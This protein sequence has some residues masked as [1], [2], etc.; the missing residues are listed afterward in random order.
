M[1]SLPADVLVHIAASFLTDAEACRFSQSDLQLQS[2]LRTRYVLKEP[3][4][5]AKWKEIVLPVSASSSAASA[6]ASSAFSSS[7]S[8]TAL[9]AVGVTAPWQRAFGRPRLLS[10]TTDE[11]FALT[12]L[13]VVAPSATEMHMYTPDEYTPTVLIHEWRL[14]AR[15][16][17]LTCSSSD[18]YNVEPKPVLSTFHLPDML[19]RLDLDEMVGR[20]L[21]NEQLHSEGKLTKFPATLT[22][23]RLPPWS[24]QEIDGRFFTLPP[25]LL[26][27]HNYRWAASHPPLPS[28]L[29]T[30]FALSWDAS[31][32]GCAIEFP[33]SLTSLTYDQVD[34]PKCASAPSLAGCPLLTE[35]DLDGCFE[36]PLSSFDL[37]P[38]LTRLSGIL[39]SQ[40]DGDWMPPDG[41]LVLH[42]WRDLSRASSVPPSVMRWPPQLREL[43]LPIFSDGADFSTMKLPE[44]LRVI[45]LRD[46]PGLESA[47][48]PSSLREMTCAIHPFVPLQWNGG[49]AVLRLRLSRFDRAVVDWHPPSSLTEL[50]MPDTW[51]QP[52]AQLHLPPRL[53]KL[54]F[55]SAFDQP[56]QADMKWPD[57]LETLTFGRGFNRSLAQWTPP[58]NL[59]LLRLIC[60]HYRL[61]S[62]TTSNLRVPR[63]LRRLRLES[64]HLPLL[65]FSSEEWPSLESLELHH[66]PTDWSNTQLPP[67]LRE[68]R[69]D[70]FSPES[71]ESF[72]IRFQAPAHL[73][74]VVV[75]PSKADYRHY[76]AP[77]LDGPTLRRIRDRLPPTCAFLQVA[78]TS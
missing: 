49:L 6:A 56:I 24:Q 15:L 21:I 47:Q 39:A 2:A 33:A 32:D 18:I 59:T 61:V 51:N 71:V 53:R 1:N 73:Q 76:G 22:Y 25:N 68:L 14:P 9:S 10:V 57:T 43:E 40:L 4:P 30:L 34:G 28:S 17:S 74:S 60:P 44:T 70:Q 75:D 11:D 78:V 27:L 69:L 38:S 55:G 5:A 42:T 64:H 8:S 52:V 16:R 23:L 54:T 7:A 13:D 29:R 65:H 31:L 36:A 12:Q 67:R 3:I 63:S 37:P 62:L 35:L 58:P 77:C 50:E 66:A 41:L 46:G 20:Y 26:E 19:E 45:K 48:W 72:L